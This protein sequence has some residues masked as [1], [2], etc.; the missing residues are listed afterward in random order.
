MRIRVQRYTTLFFLASFGGCVGQGSLEAD[1]RI[2]YQCAA[3]EEGIPVV[4]AVSALLKSG[5]LSVDP[6][7]SFFSDV[8]NDPVVNAF[9]AEWR[10]HEEYKLLNATCYEKVVPHGAFEIEF[11]TL[12]FGKVETIAAFDGSEIKALTLFLSEFD[13]IIE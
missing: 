2:P 7:R 4:S 10:Q 1:E 9:L 6:W 5:S 13:N 3:R 8:L 12:T 11:S